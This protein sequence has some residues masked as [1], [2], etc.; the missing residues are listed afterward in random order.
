MLN[1]NR[2]EQQYIERA[3]HINLHDIDYDSLLKQRSHHTYSALGIGA[4]FF[5]VGILL[6]VAEILPD[7]PG[8]GSMPV[9]MILLTGLM[10]IFYALRYQREIETRVTYDILQRIQA[11]EGHD[12]FLWRINTI[13]N[14]YCQE[15]YGG[16]PE[17]IQQLQISSQAGGIEMSEIRLYKDVLEKTINWYRNNMP[18]D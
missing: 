5:M 3:Q 1:L 7:I 9:S 18:E 2:T 4:C 16:L 10:I 12:G 13:V 14:A 6:F 11:V 17:S 15:Q 8:I